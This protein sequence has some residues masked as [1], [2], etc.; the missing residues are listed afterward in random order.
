M[1]GSRGGC[2][3]TS[4]SLFTDAQ[5]REDIAGQGRTRLEGRGVGNQRAVPAMEHGSG[6]SL[7]AFRLK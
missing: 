6:L 7:N 4:T 5:H 2:L 3:I 1:A